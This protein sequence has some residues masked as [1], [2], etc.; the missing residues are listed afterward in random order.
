MGRWSASHWKTAT[1]GWLAFVIASFAIGNVIGTK[2]I[3]PNASGSGESGHVMKVLSTDFKQPSHESVLIR[4]TGSTTDDPAFRAAVADTVAALHG[5]SVV[6]DI[7]SPLAAGNAG[8]ISPDKHAALVQFNLRG[9]DLDQSSKD[10]VAV[11]AAVAK[12]QAAHSGLAIGEFGDASI[13]EQ[14][15]KQVT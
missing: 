10:V 3:D 6:R 12:V 15:N 2:T 9:T 1:F 4:S 11:E 8:Q 13:N 7:Q 14:L 5:Q